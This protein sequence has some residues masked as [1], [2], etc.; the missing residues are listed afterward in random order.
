VRARVCLCVRVRVYVCVPTC[1]S[2]CVR[3]CVS[4][5]ACVRVRAEGVSSEAGGSAIIW[6][7]RRVRLSL[8]ACILQY[9]DDSAWQLL[10]TVA[11]DNYVQ[12]KS[13]C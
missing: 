6:C 13:N 4:V 8:A 9:N 11:D 1:A 5:R 2:M 7:F 12:C 3:A 10:R